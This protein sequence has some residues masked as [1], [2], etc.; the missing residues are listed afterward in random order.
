MKKNIYLFL[1]IIISIS[2]FGQSDS[3]KVKKSKK[4]GEILWEAYGGL[5]FGYNKLTGGYEGDAHAGG[6]YYGAD[7][8]EIG[9]SSFAPSFNLSFGGRYKY[10]NM[11]ISGARSEYNNKFILEED[12][13]IDDIVIPAGSE[14][15]GTIGNN[16]LTVA[17][18]FNII[19]RKHDLGIGLGMMFYD[20]LQR[21]SVIGSDLVSEMNPLLPMPFLAISGRLNFDKFKIVGSG[22]GAFFNGSFDDNKFKVIYY[23]Y[24]IKGSYQLLQKNKWSSEIALGYR[25]L[26]MDIENNNGEYWFLAKNTYLGPFVGLVVKFT[27]LR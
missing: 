24:E 16:V 13:A 12:R 9:M 25:N 3:T 27:E 18:T 5:R 14:V 17:T 21:Y 10:W 20:Y 15:E 19:R 8:D 22:G 1:I 11:F 26:F 4:E 7:Y 23:T 6:E 2:A